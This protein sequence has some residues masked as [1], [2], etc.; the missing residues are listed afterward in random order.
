MLLFSG[1]F[2][3]SSD[4]DSDAL[5]LVS[6]DILTSSNFGGESWL[7]GTSGAGGIKIL[8]FKCLKILK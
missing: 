6:F 1:G 7:G 5:F 8:R 2:Y 3:F 4:T